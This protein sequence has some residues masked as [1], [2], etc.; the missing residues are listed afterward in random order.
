MW[1][2]KLV[3][4]NLSQNEPRSV[5]YNL[6]LKVEYTF[7][8]GPHRENYHNMYSK[9]PLGNR[10]LHDESFFAITREGKLLTNRH[11]IFWAMSRSLGIPRLFF[12]LR[13]LVRRR[14]INK[15]NNQ[16]SNPRIRTKWISVLFNAQSNY[17]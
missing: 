16:F 13:C 10:S 15:K 8:A 11:F 2:G 5:L 12:L 1:I 17:A 9:C 6:R 14:L 4:L 3:R 7:I